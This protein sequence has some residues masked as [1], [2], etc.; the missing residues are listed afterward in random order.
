VN[1][2]STLIGT[3]AGPS[4]Q[5]DNNSAD[6]S[7]TALDLQVEAGKA[8][9]NVYSCVKMANL[10][11]DRLDDREASSFANGANEGHRRRQARRQVLFDL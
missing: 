7:V 2:L 9:M 5:V 8:P 11:A 3:V 1:A 10:N 6:A 4:L